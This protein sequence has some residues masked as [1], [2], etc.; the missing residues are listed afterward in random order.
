MKLSNFR[1]RT[2]MDALLS[3][4][5]PAILVILWQIFS[6]MGWISTE[7]LPAPVT[8][9]RTAIHLARSGELI[10]HIDDSA[11]RALLGL[12]IGGSIGL[13]L[14]FLNGISRFAEK[15]LDSTVQM[16][17]NIPHLALIPL[18]I[19][20][21]GI[22]EESKLF[23]VALGVFFPIYLNTFHGIR[24]VDPGLLEMGKIFRLTKRALFWHI[25]LP[26]ALPSILIGFR[27]ALGIM[28]LTLIVAETISSDSGIGYMAMNA[29][30]FMQMDVVVLSI[31]LYALL[32]KLA[33]LVAKALEK[34]C[35]RWRVNG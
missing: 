16:L 33:D 14:G 18:A 11:V 25:I 35:L 29:R 1:W 4:S 9:I 26:N 23:L 8:V 7:T 21:F 3:W 5:L 10:H 27:Y 19:M 20:W 32:G 17:R 24:S 28:W 15:I 13:V 2:K 30:E 22:G 31:L 34:R 12:A 6:S